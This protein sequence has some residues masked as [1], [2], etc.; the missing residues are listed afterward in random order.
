[1]DRARGKGRLIRRS[2]RLA[3][4]P[5]PR[6][7]V[8]PIPICQK[9]NHTKKV[10]SVLRAGEKPLITSKASSSLFDT[11]QDWQ[12]SPV[13][14]RQLKFPNTFSRPHS[15]LTSSW[16]E[17]HAWARHAVGREREVPRPTVVSDYHRHGRGVRCCLWRE[18]R[19][20]AGESLQGLFSTL[21]HRWKKE[22]PSLT[23]QRQWKKTP[24]GSG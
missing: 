4:R 3:A 8:V 18:T 9:P 10:I 6:A 19:D 13:F 17:R 16:C 24:C 14:G 7:S 5:L 23:A 22:G 20:F 21:D 11:T 12:L 15:D 1:M 2:L